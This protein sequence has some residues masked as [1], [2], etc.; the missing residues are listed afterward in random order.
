MTVTT[1]GME[2]D[3]RFRLIRR[4]SLGVVLVRVVA[5]MLNRLLTIMLAIR[6]G[7]RP[8]KLEW[9]HGKQKNEHQSF[10]T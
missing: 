1:V 8:G 5:K 6:S 7:R 2:F 9:Q 3:G 4:V 10:H